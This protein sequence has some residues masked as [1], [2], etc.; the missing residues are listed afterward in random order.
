MRNAF[1]ADMVRRFRL[2]KGHVYQFMVT[3]D[4]LGL[5]IKKN[6]F[7]L[8]VVPMPNQYQFLTDAQ[9]VT[10]FSNWLRG[11]MAADILAAGPD[12]AGNRQTTEPWTSPYI[13][14]AYKR[15]QLNAYLAAKRKDGTIDANQEEFLR[16]SFNAPE[17]RSKLELLGTRTFEGMKGVTEAVASD[18]NRI[19][20]T[21]MV[22]GDGAIEIANAM[23]GRI[24][25]ITRTRALT[26][27]RTEIIHA[28]A[29]GQLDSFE[30][31]GVEELGIN[32]EWS[33]AGDDR[34]CPLCQPLEGKVFSMKDARGK[35]PLHPNCRCSWV[36][37]DKA[38]S[39]KK[40]KRIDQ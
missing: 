20:A 5:E 15:G 7:A 37:T 16:E 8:N 18:L 24:D 39:G 19:L 6:P 10:A 14:S 26:I 9:K 33:T 23:S 31:L 32:A 34:V 13:E 30:K 4:A 2:L 28:H 17:T 21:G 11:Q 35:I 25:S 12:A 1:M 22:N 38:V 40:P 27:A 29:E 36:P 3:L